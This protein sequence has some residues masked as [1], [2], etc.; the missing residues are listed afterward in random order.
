[1]SPTARPIR[2]SASTESAT[3]TTVTSVSSSSPSSGTARLRV[4]VGRRVAFDEADVVQGVLLDPEPDEAGVH[5]VLENGPPDR[6]R[7]IAPVAEQRLHTRGHL[8]L[9][10]LALGRDALQWV[11]FAAR[12]DR[13]LLDQLDVSL[14]R[15]R[16]ADLAAE[17]VVR[18]PIEDARGERGT[19]RRDE[20][21]DHEPEDGGPAVPEPADREPDR[22]HYSSPERSTVLMP[23]RRTWRLTSTTVTTNRTSAA[24]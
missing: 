2:S 11:D 5:G 8:G 10:L 19:E 6:L 17:R 7:E 18:E 16:L 9:E 21:E 12:R 23:A 14:E 20:H 3:S 1:M 4:S 15:R 22:G 13:R 24:T